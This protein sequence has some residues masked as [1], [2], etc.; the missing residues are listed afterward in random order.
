[1]T[2]STGWSA[3]VRREWVLVLVAVVVAVGAAAAAPFMSQPKAVATAQVLSDARLVSAFPGVP[4]LDQVIAAT[5]SDDG[6]SAIAAA[7]GVTTTEVSTD[8]RL[9]QLTS[10]LYGV[11]VSATSADEG[12]AA[13][14][15][16]AAATET[17]SRAEALD[18]AQIGR[19]HTRAAL[20]AQ[21]LGVIQPATV[22]SPRDADL[23]LKYWTVSIA[24]ND[25]SATAVTLENAF[26]VGGAVTVAR[27]SQT[28]RALQNVLAAILA[29]LAVGL[30]IAALRE[31]VVGR[32][33]RPS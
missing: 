32:E 14:I 11:G 2:G 9:T 17:V 7:S 24:A 3:V 31:W 30:G 27:P 5:T 10:P 12:A 28:S 33:E 25:D 13:L 23:A 29:G 26:R 19:F 6:L 15:A 20:D 1:M 21:A 8:L 16:S 4:T 18:A 22:A